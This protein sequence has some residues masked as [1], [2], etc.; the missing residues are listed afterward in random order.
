MLMNH[1]MIKFILFIIAGALIIYFG[2][3]KDQYTVLF[4]I[5]VF[6]CVMTVAKY[7]ICSY[8]DNL[9]LELDKKKIQL[10][11]QLDNL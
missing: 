7:A 10:Q 5:I 6:G 8:F 1:E 4:I 3:G 11:M 9:L 2:D